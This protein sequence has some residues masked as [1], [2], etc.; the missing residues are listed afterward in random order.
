M[1]TKAIGKKI[2]EL[3]FKS[4]GVRRDKFGIGSSYLAK[5][6]SSGSLVI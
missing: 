1:V 4:L 2:L 6:I 3:F 5:K